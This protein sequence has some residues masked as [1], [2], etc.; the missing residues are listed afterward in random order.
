MSIIQDILSLSSW[1]NSLHFA[2][3]LNCSCCICFYIV[4]ILVHQ[5]E[6]KNSP[7]RECCT[8][9]ETR[10]H[11]ALPSFQLIQWSQTEPLYRVTSYYISTELLFSN[12]SDKAHVGQ[13]VI[14]PP[15]LYP[16]VS[17]WLSGQSVCH[18]SYDIISV[19]LSAWSREHKCLGRL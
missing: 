3:A 15:A 8:W 2:V 1:D 12:S 16:Q 6:V 17:V 19:Q 11:H 4:C 14:N 7:Y 18:P 9:S 10:A 5:V 13:P